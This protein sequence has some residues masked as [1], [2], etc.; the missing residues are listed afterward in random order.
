MSRYN[1]EET[2]ADE[3]YGHDV[4]TVSCWVCGAETED[5]RYYADTRS[6][7]CA[8]CKEG[9]PPKVDRATFAEA[10][11]RGEDADRNIEAEFYEDYLLSEY[12]LERYMETLS[13]ALPF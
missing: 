2:R 1:P 13:D 12:T 10:F 8:V 7:L 3:Q 9:T 6:A 5:V 11:R 4:V